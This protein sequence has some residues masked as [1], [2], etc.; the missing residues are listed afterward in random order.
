MQVLIKPYRRP[1]DKCGVPLLAAVRTAMVLSVLAV[2]AFCGG[3]SWLTGA[4][5]GTA[6][7][8]YAPPNGPLPNPLIVTGADAEF[9]WN[10]IVDTIDDYFDD[11]REERFQALGDAM[12]EGRISTLPQSG[13]LLFERWRKDSSPGFERWQSTFQSIRRYADVRVTPN[14]NGFAVEVQVHKELEDVDRPEFAA[15]GRAV[16]NH[17]GTLVRVDDIPNIG[18]V[19]LGWIP[20]GRD[21][22]LEQRILAD[23]HSR[24]FSV[25]SP[26]EIQVPKQLWQF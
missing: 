11:I 1:T 24:F 14:G 6:D 3:C 9:T 22:S 16:Q 15:V 21:V 4:R 23:L 25:G 13:S 7:P 26:P 12:T 18:S 20:I 2:L 8:A 10:T 5:S 17:N 19:P